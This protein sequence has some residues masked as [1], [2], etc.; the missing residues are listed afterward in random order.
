MKL[1]LCGQMTRQSH[2]L[3]CKTICVVGNSTWDFNEYSNFFMNVK[4]NLSFYL[5]LIQQEKE[6]EILL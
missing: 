1:L 5:P 4:Q 2:L 3:Y 6:E